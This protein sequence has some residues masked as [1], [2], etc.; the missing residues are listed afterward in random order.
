[1]RTWIS[2]IACAF[3]VW[4]GVTAS[5]ALT[6]TSTPTHT[7][8]PTATPTSSQ[9]PGYPVLT[10]SFNTDGDTQDWHGNTQMSVPVVANG[11][12]SAVS[13][14]V[15]PFM[16]IEGLDIPANY[17]SLVRITMR[18]AE[19]DIAQVFFT[20]N[21]GRI[22]GPINL[23][24]PGGKEFVTREVSLQSIF[25][26][27]DI[28]VE[29][30]LDPT[31]RAGIAFEIDTIELLSLHHGPSGEIVLRMDYPIDSVAYCPNGKYIAA[32]AC[33]DAAIWDVTTI[34]R[35]HTLKL[36][37]E[38]KDI[39]LSS[40][41]FLCDG[42]TLLTG[43]GAI[44][45]LFNEWGTAELWDVESG[46]RIGSLEEPD[47][48]ITSVASS[49]H[50]HLL[51]VGTS[52][53]SGVSLEPGGCCEL[54]D[55]ETG[56]QV[57]VFET[58]FDSVD[59]VAF[60]PGGQW[61][62][63]V[64]TFFNDT[65]G[66]VVV[67]DVE[68]GQQIQIFEEQSFWVNSAV[69]S[70]D[71]RFVL[72]GVGD[73][74][75][76]LWDVE[77]GEQA[78]VFNPNSG[79]VND[80]AFSSDGSLI[81]TA[82]GDPGA[83]ETQGTV[84]LWDVDSGEVVQVLQGHEGPVRSA[85]FSPDGVK[86]LTGGEDGTVRIWDVTIPRPSANAPVAYPQSLTTAVN[87]P[88]L[89]KL[90]GSDK[91]DDPITFQVISQPFHG[92][93]SGLDPETGTLKYN[94]S[95]DF[96]GVDL[97]TFK[98]N[99]GFL[100][101]N[102]A[103]V[104]IVVEGSDRFSVE[105]GPDQ[106]TAVKTSVELDATVSGGDGDYSFLWS[107]L[108]GPDF[109]SA[110]FSS[111]ASQNT[112]FTPSTPGIFVLQISVEDKTRNP[113]S[114]VVIV[115]ANPG[116]APPDIPTPKPTP[117]PTYTNT[118]TLT[119]TPTNTPTSTYTPTMTPT[120][121]YTPTYTPTFTPTQS[122]TPTSTP[123]HSPTSTNTPT[124]TPTHTPTATPTNTSTAT[125]SPTATSTPTSSPTPTPTITPTPSLTPTPFRRHTPIPYKETE[126]FPTFTPTPTP[127]PTLNDA[128]Q[129]QFNVLERLQ[130]SSGEPV[131][132]TCEL[133]PRN[134]IRSRALLTV[135]GLG[136]Q[137][138]GSFVPGD[139]VL[140]GVSI[141]EIQFSKKEKNG[142]RR[143]IAIRADAVAVNN[144]AGQVVSVTR[145]VAVVFTPDAAVDPEKRTVLQRTIPIYL[146]TDASLEEKVG[147]VV[148]IGGRLGLNP[149]LST[150]KLF[151][152]RSYG[153]PFYA[154]I[155]LQKGDDRF[156]VSV[157][158]SSSM[159]LW[160]DW[161]AV[162]QVESLDPDIPVS[163]Q[164]SVLNI[165]V[166]ALNS[167][168]KRPSD[169]QIAARQDV[170]SALFG[171]FVLVAGASGPG[172]SQETIERLIRDRYAELTDERRFTRERLSI[173]SDRPISNESAVL[174]TQLPT[175][176]VLVDR[177][178]SVPARDPLTIY[179]LGSAEGVGSFRLSATEILDV[180][181]LGSALSASR[182]TGPTLVIIDCD[183]ASAVGSAI[184][185]AAGENPCLLVIASTG[186]K[187]HNVALFGSLPST[188]QPFSFSDL[189]F[190]RI[191]AGDS[192]IDAFQ[193][194][195]DRIVQVQGPVRC[196]NPAT[197]PQP[198][199]ETFRTFS[200]G[201]PYV[202]GLMDTGVPDNAEPVIITGSETSHHVR[203][204]DLVIT[205]LVKDESAS[206]E[207]IRVLAHIAPSETPDHFAEYPMVYN[208]GSD[209]YEVL[210]ADFPLNTFDTDTS[211]DL[212]LVSI[213]AEDDSGNS[214]DPLVTSIHVS[215][216]PTRWTPR[217]TD[218]NGDGI[219][220]EDDLLN[221]RNFWQQKMEGDISG[222]NVWGP[223]D[224]FYYQ[225]GW[226]MNW[227]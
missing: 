22:V 225:L 62:L 129:F 203:G 187:E 160:G 81:L 143:N 170:M 25:E 92:E 86:V 30:R 45:E 50:G 48:F 127:Q 128:P 223:S 110:Q 32:A 120:D 91:D 161:Q 145:E 179:F 72:A 52:V 79:S 14:D 159:M 74:T 116:T 94:P 172:L 150:I 202:A 112:S 27:D 219:T 69:F 12:L 42:R 113:V 139:L 213:L 84:Q 46:E 199:P 175:T 142:F 64:G 101:S 78:G 201:S 171:H 210:L 60:S 68:T 163:G 134:E 24:F 118:P 149:G 130:Q 186:D 144:D 7:P 53:A 193:K 80:V 222:D 29:V 8:A 65:Q 155:P 73:G 181:A 177:I 108:Y 138:I 206:R 221:F 140:P 153:E 83:E 103:P 111:D 70:P 157:P 217:V 125:H 126:P 131:R 17:L 164:S 195:S 61:F 154:E 67:R 3:L 34:E 185:T 87:T 197:L 102:M 115:T 15:D 216:T 106:S 75:A 59:A 136:S 71:G 18:T 23:P 169:K 33:A 19:P 109:D 20:T 5:Q 58:G 146:T 104:A 77:T 208:P 54:W 2:T 105:T 82:C 38:R 55:A 28:I 194:A 21:A 137:T 190:D 10:W 39:L 147:D 215:N 35:V 182:R 156:I 36:G 192:L 41:T 167:A 207:A 89:I 114:N 124:S 96:A 51:L 196:Q 176:Q 141:L 49:P 100:D 31:Y 117:T 189:F 226:Y 26:P 93:L 57:Q 133:I 123:T 43:S 1:M 37:G 95:A 227:R 162:A 56:E 76:K 85:A 198:I 168:A 47:R 90:L 211:A 212:F 148:R 188:G 66:C 220:N 97:F 16:E 63:E 158:V 151:V 204:E 166:G 183:H 184:R 132:F 13:T 224:L 40:L 218:L 44:D 119:S 214:A 209:S 178:N 6:P 191:S 121:T 152:D 180:N 200:I 173:Y 9:T 174:S 122:P 135:S 88:A 107:V 205:A 165:P 98:V 4:V 11:T 99:D